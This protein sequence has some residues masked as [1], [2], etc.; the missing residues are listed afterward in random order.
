MGM[1]LIFYDLCLAWK[2]Q[3]ESSMLVLDV[4]IKW[5]YKIEKKWEKNLFFVI[6]IFISKW[7]EDKCNIIIV[8][9]VNNGFI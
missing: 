9:V 1:L 2:K 6:F 8:I 4:K 3:I 7:I 5:K